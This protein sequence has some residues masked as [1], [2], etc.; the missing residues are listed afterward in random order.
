M[1]RRLEE[2]TAQLRELAL[3]DELTG[4][5]NRRGF[6]VVSSQVLEMADRQQV[7]A[8]L[9][10]L[11]VD[12]LKELNDRLGHNAGDAGLKAVA[13]ALTHALRRAD[14][15]SRIGGDEFVALT[16][17]LDEAGQDAVEGRIR[18]YLGAALTV[19]SVGASVE[20]SVGWAERT[21]GQLVTV[22]DLLEGADRVM[23]R[24]KAT[25]RE[26]GRGQTAEKL[27]LDDPSH[28]HG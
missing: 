14:V 22:D 9:L 12:N 28:S 20:V 23:Y 21:P 10:F 24:A 13:R 4:L 7:T 27:E 11:D 6:V 1:E 3:N 17:G 19:A 15:V 16:L 26:H 5:R 2:I 18:E 8:H 25:K